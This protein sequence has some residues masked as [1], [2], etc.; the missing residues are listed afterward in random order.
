MRKA[1]KATLLVVVAVILLGVGLYFVPPIRSRVE[2]RF[3]D[4]IARIQYS[5]HPPEKNVFVPQGQQQIAEIVQATFQ[6]LTPPTPP[7]PGPTVDTHTEPAATSP[8]LA[9]GGDSTPAP[10]AT[11]TPTSTPLPAS[12]ILKGVK[13][14]YQQWNNCGPATLS[15][16]LSYWG[17]QGSQKDTA[18]FM[19]PNPRDKNVMPYEMLAY[20]EQQTNLKAVVRMGGD[21]ETIK[22]FVAAG[23]PVVIEKGFEVE[24]EGW[25]GHYEVVTGYDDAKRRLITQDSYIMPDLPV[26]YAELEP[27]W[28]AFN[29]IYLVIYSPDREGD[30]LALLG[31]QADETTAFQEAAARASDEIPALSGRD[32]YFAWYNRGTSLV[33]LADYA[34]AA[35]AYD[36]AFAVY[37]TIPE[38]KRPWRMVWYQTGPYFAYEYTGRYADVI[39]LATTTINALSE[40]AIEESFVW[41]AR[42]RI[43]VG[44]SAGAVDDLRAALKWHPGFEPALGELA[45]LGVEP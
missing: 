40:P 27:A 29:Y 24:K 21:L 41:R 33:N 34:G 9:T 43:A 32:L 39:N 35:Q 3:S 10:S 16:A 45:N 5:L 26:P 19:K 25:M 31:S 38:K 13:H 36:E 44:D 2:W 7:D 23:F 17:W 20:V 12:K 37:P 6:A 22:R 1:V 18:A 42:A 8:T 28:R 4:L 30:V 15:M 11:P 14:E